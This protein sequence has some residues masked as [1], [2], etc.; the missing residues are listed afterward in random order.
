MNQSEQKTVTV[1]GASSRELAPA[2]AEAARQ[3]GEL[4]AQRGYRCVLGGGASGV[5]GNVTD[6][7]MQAGGHVQGVIP[8]WMVDKGW[9]YDRLDDVLVTADMHQRQEMLL[10]QAHAVVAMPGGCGTLAEL[11]EAITWRQLGLITMPIVI[12]N[13][14][15]FFDPLLEMMRQCAAQRL[16][17]PSHLRLWQVAESPLAAVRAVE[18]GWSEG[19]TAP[20]DKL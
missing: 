19:C 3:L 7:V 12:L 2:I 9:C 1:F 14:D 11:T 16:M 20:E 17:K 8:K 15:H 18:R 5:M 4:L 13:V 10:Q 6:G